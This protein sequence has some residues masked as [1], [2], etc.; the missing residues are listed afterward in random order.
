MAVLVFCTSYSVQA[1]LFL[2]TI[3]REE[4][5]IAGE[6]LC[7]ISSLEVQEEHGFFV[8]VPIDYKEPLKG[9]TSLYVHTNKPFRPEQ[10]SLIFFDGGPGL[11]SHMDFIQDLPGWNIIRFDQRGVA[12]SRP[13]TYRQYRDVSFYS[14]ENTAKDAELIRRAMKIKTWSVF[15]GSYGTV[16]ATI[17]AS[18]FPKATRSLTLE[19]VVFSGEEELWGGAHRRKLL[20]HLLNT[21]SLE[22]RQELD[23]FTKDSQLPAYWFSAIAN[24]QMLNNH[25]LRDFRQK[26]V[27]FSSIRP[28]VTEQFKAAMASPADPVEREDIL[29]IEDSMVFAAIACKELS[30][31]SPQTAV[32]DDLLDGKLVPSKHVQ[33]AKTVCQP[34]GISHKPDTVFSALKYPVTVPVTYFQGAHDGATTSTYAIDHYKKVRRGKGQILILRHGGHTPNLEI[35]AGDGPQRELQQEFFLNALRG[36]MIAPS[37][38]EKFNATGEERWFFKQSL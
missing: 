21:S 22:T 13:A 38:I 24:A 4:N 19:G 7:A 36:E 25:G 31:A 16:P 6:K 17:Y 10:P 32:F 33:T 1:S 37:Q 34:A 9:S 11:P 2:P 35:L 3:L 5:Y 14:S 8:Q 12:C 18:W 26:L 20:Q 27:N 30:M 28:Q 23:A 15:A 29:S